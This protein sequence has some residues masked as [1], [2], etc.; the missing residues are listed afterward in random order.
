MWKIQFYRDTIN[1]PNSKLQFITVRKEREVEVASD[2]ES[3]ALRIKEG[4]QHLFRRP[5]EALSSK[6]VQEFWVKKTEM[7]VNQGAVIFQAYIKIIPQRV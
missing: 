5:I 4:F 2:G 3:E 6:K 7:L 1:I